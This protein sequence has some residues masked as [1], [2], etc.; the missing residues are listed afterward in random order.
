MISKFRVFPFVL[1]LVAGALAPIASAHSRI[2]PDRS[3]DLPQ[4]PAIQTVTLPNGLRVLLRHNTEPL[5]KVSLRLLVRVGS[6]HE[7]DDEKGLAHFVEHMLFRGTRRH[8]GDSLSQLLQREGLGYG[9]DNTAF[10]NFDHT[11][12]HLELPRNDEATLRLALSVFFEY[13]SEAT[14]DAAALDTERGVVLSEKAMRDTPELRYSESNLEYLWPHSLP[15]RRMVIGDEKV[16]RTAPRERL[17]AFYDAWYR[18]ERMAVIIVGDVD[19]EL[20]KRLAE[21]ILGPM[22]ARGPAREDPTDFTPGVASEPTPRVYTDRGMVGASIHFQAPRKVGLEIDNTERRRRQVQRDLAMTAFQRRL[23]RVA[24]EKGESFVSPSISVNPN[25]LEWNVT[26]LWV[27]TRMPLWHDATTLAEQELRRAYESGFL[28]SEIA[29]AKRQFIESLDAD[30]RGAKSRSS[31]MLAG[32]LAWSLLSGFPV[33]SPEHYRDEWT[34]FLINTSPA[35]CLEAFRAA[36]GPELPHA[37]L[38]GHVELGATQADLSNALE[39]SRKVALQPQTERAAPE[40]AYNVFGTEGHLVAEKFEQDLDLRL[41]EYG[42]GVRFNF[43]STRFAED[44]VQIIARIPGGRL[45]LKPNQAG[46]DWFA[47]WAFIAGGLRRHNPAEMSD[48]LAGRSIGLQFTVGNDSFYLTARCARRDLLLTLKLIAAHLTDPGWREEALP[49]SKAAYGSMFSSLLTTPGA[50]IRV[51]A[52]RILFDDPRFGTPSEEEYYRHGLKQLAGWLGPQLRNGALELS[53][54]GDTSWD[55][56]Q[57]AVARTLGALAKREPWPKKA[58]KLPKFIKPQERPISFTVRSDFKQSAIAWVFPARSLN[59]VFLERRARLLAD[60][61]EERIRVR[62]R[63]ELGS[64]YAPEAQLIMDESLPG[65]SYF[66]VYAEVDHQRTAEALAVLRAE[67]D[68]LPRQGVTD[69]EFER[70]KAP[71]LHARSDDVRRNEYWLHTVMADVQQ[72]PERLIAARNR[73]A[74]SAAITRAEVEEI[75]RAAVKRSDGFLFISEPA[76]GHNWAEK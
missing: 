12:Y 44:Y 68:R 23:T 70:I 7:R 5:G 51:S 24:R 11:I 60:L 36:W 56:A 2:W 64:A 49:Q 1:L 69:D 17:A 67:L 59:T 38:I 61:L 32:Q 10:T 26:S 21:E 48:I 55:E 71:F 27:S 18:P 43:K 14:L 74:D 19:L 15:A 25:F 47:S 31:E 16:I 35:E 45:S 41:C 39:A 3:S 22:T 53:I 72:R 9:P 57:A 20:A 66:V 46:L 58:P 34:E 4:D 54:V 76:P 75:L 65:L 63:Q 30:V 40:F 13:G 8:P 42:N 50:P 6:L 52:E 73:A 37:T 33:A 28:E 29:T 62:L